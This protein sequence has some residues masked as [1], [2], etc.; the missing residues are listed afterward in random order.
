MP[1]PGM[2]H[3]KQA[4]RFFFEKTSTSEMPPPGMRHEKQAFR[5]F[6]EKTSTSEIKFKYL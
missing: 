3:E 5:F 2:R 1:P 6:F 4:F